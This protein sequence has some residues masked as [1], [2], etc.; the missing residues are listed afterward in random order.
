MGRAYLEIFKSKGTEV[1]HVLSV[2]RRDNTHCICFY[3]HEL[4]K[5]THE[6]RKWLLL[7][8][9]TNGGQNGVRLISS[10]FGKYSKAHSKRKITREGVI[11]LYSGHSRHDQMADRKSSHRKQKKRVKGGKRCQLHFLQELLHSVR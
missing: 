5:N 10:H 3:V 4:S 2:T 1:G 7:G 6:P 8:R 9:W 11:T